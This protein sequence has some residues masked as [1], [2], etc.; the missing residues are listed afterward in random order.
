MSRT[1]REEVEVLRAVMEDSAER[2]I[3]VRNGL[4]LFSTQPFPDEEVQFADYIG[5]RRPRRII[6]LG[7]GPGS[8]ATT[9]VRALAPGGRMF[10]VDISEPSDAVE[11]LERLAAPE[12]AFRWYQGDSMDE[13]TR[14]IALEFV[15]GPADLVFLDTDH[16]VESTRAEIE[17]WWPAVA[18]G[19]LMGFHDIYTC[20]DGVQVA[21]RELCEG[22]SYCAFR[23][24]GEHCYGI[25]VVLKE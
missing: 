6:E 17:M 25:G 23:Q 22:K 18:E 10:S 11:A 21:F 16:T 13:G 12:R 20:E 2:F 5:M 24:Q 9:L 14:E 8:F 15:G 3:K 19:G 1:L 4:S 7:T